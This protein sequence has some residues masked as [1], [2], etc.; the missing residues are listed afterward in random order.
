MHEFL[1]ALEHAL[2]DSL[3]MLPFLLVAFFV[4]EYIETRLEEKSSSAIE[5]AGKAGPFVGALLGI[6]PQCGFS[7]IGSNFYAKRIITVGTLIAIFLSTSDEALLIML[8]SPE[9]FVDM[10]LIVGIKLVIAVVAGYAIDLLF[11]CRSE[12]DAQEECHHCHHHDDSC[13]DEELIGEEHCCSHTD[14]KAIIKCTAKRTVSVW[15]FIFIANLVIELAIAYIGEESLSEFMLVGS[16]FQPM[17][18]ALI[19]LIPNCAPS[20][21]LA[22]MYIEGTIGLGSVIA[23]LCTSAGVGL[24]VLFRVN[25]GFK[26]N[27]AVIASLFA[28]S[29][30]SGVVIQALGL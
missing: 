5:K 17:L 23:G 1:H 25:K 20:V 2:L 12:G 14:F 28:I 29:A 11:R 4:L 19:G 3:K 26:Q 30:L 22:Q 27:I 24:L 21:I 13:E 8:A 6:I 9:H 15:F 7:V 16:I 10:L 18:T